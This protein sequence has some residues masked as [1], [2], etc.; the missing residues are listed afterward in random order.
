MKAL[1]KVHLQNHD[2]VERTKTERKIL[3]SEEIK[4]YKLFVILS[5]YTFLLSYITSVT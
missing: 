3:V 5:F 1:K 2:Q 4:S